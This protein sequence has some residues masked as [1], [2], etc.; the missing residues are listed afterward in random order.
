L[1]LLGPLLLRLSSGL[2]MLLLLRLLGPLLL[3][4]P[5]GLGMFLLLG[6]LC[7]LLLLLFSGGLSVV[8]RLVPFFVLLAALRIRGNH[9]RE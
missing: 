6:L 7:P 8:L 1:T 5:G 4:P 3:L 9:R 2:G